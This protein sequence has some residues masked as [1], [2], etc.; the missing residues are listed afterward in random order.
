MGNNKW[1]MN[2]LI[3]ETVGLCM[4]RDDGLE[5]GKNHRRGILLL[6]NFT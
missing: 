5:R 4:E 1:E 3:R 2:E 6:S